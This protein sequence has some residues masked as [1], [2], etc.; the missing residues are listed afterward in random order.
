MSIADHD[1][2]PQGPHQ[3]ASS[4]SPVDVYALTDEVPPAPPLPGRVIVSPTEDELIDHVAAD[5]VIQAEACVR[6]FG[7]FHLALTSGAPLQ[8]LYDR[9]MYDPNYRRLPWR[10]TH[11]WLVDTP[12]VPPDDEWSGFRQIDETLVDHADIPGDQVHPIHAESRKAD[13]DY[14]SQL[15]ET[16]AWREKGH[17]RLDY[18]LL[19]L[20]TDGHVGG[21]RPGSVGVSDEE[22][23]AVRSRDD[24]ADRVTM[25]LRMINASR[26]VAVTGI[27]ASVSAA[28]GRLSSGR[29]SVDD[30]TAAG[31]APLNGELKWYLDADA[32]P[33]SADS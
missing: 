1:S 14:E 8:R 10:R 19:L 24:D 12:C 30:M 2:G 7:D 26:L 22:R 11:L 13:R 4:R 15:R 21:L 29:A 9:L 5:L 32:C 6:K 17:D 16:L 33:L 27:G 20:G 28:V 25:T 31:L 18:V 23:L 3:H